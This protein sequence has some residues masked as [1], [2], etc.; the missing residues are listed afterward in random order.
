[1]KTLVEFFKDRGV[2]FQQ[3]ERVDLKSFGIRKRID[4]FKGV[5]TKNAYWAI[6]VIKRKSRILQKDAKELLALVQA[7]PFEHAFKKRALLLQ[8]PIC[9]KAKAFLQKQGWLVDAFV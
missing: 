2:V 3:L 8:A 7:L 6:F 1:M 5:D 9:S 4:F